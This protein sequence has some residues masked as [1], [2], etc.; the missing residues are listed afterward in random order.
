MNVTLPWPSK[1]LSPN[2]RVHW[3]KKSK[4]AKAYRHACHI[5]TLESKAKID[6]DGDVHVWIDFYRPSR[7]EMD[8]DNCLARIKSGLDGVADALGINDSR[9]RPHP[10]IKDEIGGMVKL[11]FTKG[12]V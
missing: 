5:L 8:H 2:A 10:Y 12:P 9:F 3:S 1:D 7:R 4:A 6:W 11:T